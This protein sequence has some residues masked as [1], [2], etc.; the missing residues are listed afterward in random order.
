M[1]AATK[2]IANYLRQYRTTLRGI[3]D[4]IHSVHFE[5]DDAAEIRLSHLREILKEV[6]NLKECLS[7]A[8]E[9]IDAIPSESAAKFPTMPGFDRDY[10]SNILSLNGVEEHEEKRRLF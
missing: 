1:S 2:G 3:G 7:W 5:G 10:V 6:E 4:V 9:Y 8:L